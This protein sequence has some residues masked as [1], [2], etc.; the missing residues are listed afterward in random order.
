MSSATALA[1]TLTVPEA[2]S[3]N[4]ERLLTLLGSELQLGEVEAARRAVAQ[5]GNRFPLH[6]KLA[7]EAGELLLQ[8]SLIDE[9]EI[10]F[11]RASR[12]LPKRGNESPS[13]DLNLYVV[14]LQMAR[15][16]FDR[17]DC[18]SA[19]QCFDRIEL[20]QV[21]N[22]LQPSALHL[23]GQALVGVGRPQEALARLSEAARMNPCNPEFLVHLAWADIGWPSEIS[24]FHHGIGRQQMARRS[25]S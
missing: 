5:R 13:G 22:S 7:Y 23:E 6:A 21:A 19:L 17:K 10:E 8:Y 4:S 1:G 2:N 24:G 20:E 9:A 15:L 14:Q 3:Q 12:L 25:R 16:Q 11:R 18:W